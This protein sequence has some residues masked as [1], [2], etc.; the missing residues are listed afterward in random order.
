M[1]RFSALLTLFLLAALVLSACSSGNSGPPTSDIVSAIPWQGN[2]SHDYLLAD[3]SGKTLGNETLAVAVNGATTTLTQDFKND[4]GTDVS[5]VV[6]DSQTLKPQ[7]ATRK[8][9]RP[10]SNVDL[11]ITY[12]DQGALIKQD[13]KQSGL[14]V[15]DHSYDNDSSLFL[16]RTIPFA[17]GYEASY[18]TII[19]NQR[20][21][22]TVVLQVT[23]KE[24]VAV[25]SGTFDAW[26]L[27]IR[28]STAR[29]VAWF[30]DT[31]QHVLLKYDNDRG[32]IFE[33]SSPP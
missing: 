18:V 13:N 14:S 12:T 20:S 3:K 10:D 11:Q 31:P 6:V 19:T 4:T 29:Q 26:R 8:I 25:P 1:R 23:G 30:T 22:Q 21:R 27:E 15:P 28:T 24:T 2:E 17:Q 7:T 9:V 5:N 33:L 32:L 16:W